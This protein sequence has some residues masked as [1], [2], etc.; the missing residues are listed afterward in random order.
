MFLYTKAFDKSDGSV[1]CLIVFHIFVA[2]TWLTLGN[3]ILVLVVDAYG[4]V[5]H[6]TLATYLQAF[7]FNITVMVAISIP[8]CV[9]KKV[10]ESEE[11]VDASAIDTNPQYQT[12]NS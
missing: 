6:L 2:L 10:E 3:V 4:L 12:I 1:C 5:G 7:V 8:W 9:A 11:L